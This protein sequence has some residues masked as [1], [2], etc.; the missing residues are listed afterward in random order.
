[1]L[2][3]ESLPVEK[4]M[5]DLSTAMASELGSM[6]VTEQVDAIRVFGINPNPQADRACLP[7]C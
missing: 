2:T 1:V 7:W 3:G 5:T 6:V 4:T